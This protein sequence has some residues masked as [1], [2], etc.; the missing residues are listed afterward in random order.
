MT[1]SYP[2]AVDIR[3][4]AEI[5]SNPDE[6][7]Y[8]DDGIEASKSDRKHTGATPG[9]IG[10]KSR[11]SV[12]PN[13]SRRAR[14]SAENKRSKDTLGDIWEIDEVRPEHCEEQFDP[15]TKPEYEITYRQR[16]SANNVY[17]PMSNL[18]TNGRGEEDLVVRVILPGDLLTE[19]TLEVTSS[20][21]NLASPN[22][23]LHLPLPRSVDQGKGV[24]T[25]DPSTHTLMVTL[26]ELDQPLLTPAEHQDK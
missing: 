12:K 13:K 11:S 16:L 17:L 26:P 15:R 20:T 10:S 9:T 24:A 21:L 22:Y 3:A 18:A 14:T 2:P 25:W 6:D 8:D 5:L 19:V 23:L 1:S 7:R 4:L